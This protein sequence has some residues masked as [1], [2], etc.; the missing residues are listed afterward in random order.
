MPKVHVLYVNLNE[1]S[2]LRHVEFPEY[3]DD[4]DYV[5]DAMGTAAYGEGDAIVIVGGTVLKGTVFK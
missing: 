3:D 5:R 1:S 4:W 2:D